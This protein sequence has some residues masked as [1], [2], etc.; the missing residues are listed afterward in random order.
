MN[1][2]IFSLGIILLV[3]G[4]LSDIFNYYYSYSWYLIA[5]GVVLMIIGAFV[6]SVVKS[7]VDRDEGRSSKTVVRGD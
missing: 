2:G 7:T 6:P 3:L 1:S 5:G 4:I